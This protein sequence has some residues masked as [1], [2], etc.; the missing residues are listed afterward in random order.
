MNYYKSLN[1]KAFL[2]AASNPD[3][4]VFIAA[5]K[6]EYEAALALNAAKNAEWKAKRKK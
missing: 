6:D 3:P 1:G 2:K 5:T 4:E